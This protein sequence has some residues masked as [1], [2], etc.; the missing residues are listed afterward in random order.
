MLSFLWN[1]FLNGY[2]FTFSSV[3]NGLYLN[4]YVFAF[5][6]FNGMLMCSNSCLIYTTEYTSFIVFRMKPSPLEI[7]TLLI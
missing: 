4:S 3:F 5:L 2:V 1:I 7:D 6:V